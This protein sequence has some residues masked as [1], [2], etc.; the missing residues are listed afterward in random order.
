MKLNYLVRC[1]TNGRVVL[2]GRAAVVICGT[3]YAEL[4]DIE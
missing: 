2:I 1:T 3:N 4:I